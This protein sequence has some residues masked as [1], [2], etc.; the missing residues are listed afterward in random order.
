MFRSNQLFHVLNVKWKLKLFD[1]IDN[2]QSDLAIGIGFYNG[3][4]LQQSLAVLTGCDTG[5]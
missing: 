5:R 2:R 1:L 3:N 4:A